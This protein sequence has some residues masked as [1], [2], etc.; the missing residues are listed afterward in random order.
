[1]SKMKQIAALTAMLVGVIMYASPAKSAVCFL[2]D[3][4]G[5]CGGGDI[6]IS[7]GSDSDDNKPEEK[8]EGF[9]VSA[10][11]YEKMKNC[12]DFTS[13]TKSK[14]KEVKYKKGAQ[15]ENTTWSNGICCTNG[16]KYFSKQGRCCPTTGCTCSGGRVW[17]PS[18]EQCECP[19]GKEFVG[20]VCTCAG[21]TVPD[22]KGNCIL[23]DGCTYEYRQATTEDS[24]GLTDLNKNYQCMA[25]INGCQCYTQLIKVSSV[26]ASAGYVVPYNKISNKS[27]T[28]VDEN[29]VTRYQ[30]ICKGTTKSSCSARGKNYEFKPN[31]CVSDTYN[32]GFEVKGDEWGDCVE[33]E[34]KCHYQ[35]TLASRS[36]TC[37]N[38]GNLDDGNSCQKGTCCYDNL[39]KV[40]SIRTENG[41]GNVMPIYNRISNASASCVTLD[42][43]T[44]YETICEG[45]PKS[46]CF[47][48]SNN[49]KFTPNGCV[50]FAYNNDFE[51]KGTE[52]G[53][54]GCDESK[55]AYATIEKCRSGTNSG[56]TASS[57]G[58]YQT[59]ESQG[60]YSTKEA[61]LNSD[62]KV[63][64]TKTANTGDCYKREMKGFL[65]KYD[66][67]K[68][69]AMCGHTSYT[70]EA[71]AFLNTVEYNSERKGEY[72]G[73][74]P[75]TV[76]GKVYYELPEDNSK[77][78]QYPAG[79]YYL[80]YQGRCSS[81]GSGS[82]EQDCPNFDVRALE[83]LRTTDYNSEFTKEVCFTG[84]DGGYVGNFG[85]CEYSHEASNNR[86]SCKKVT[87]EAGKIY[88]V[89]FEISG[90]HDSSCTYQ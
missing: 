45:T 39:S 12:F 5:S 60:Y 86:E 73:I 64:C 43:V 85:T 13:C 18:T 17:N 15:K 26:T 46:A 31:G 48:F 55:G 4:D 41:E 56:C 51:V 61:C 84:R 83:L 50:S 30:T 36:N 35:Y 65:I 10:T 47:R 76:D 44:K 74:P 54:C 33:K 70:A 19:E 24:C 11:E 7:D 9:P 16:E 42:G 32:N 81:S 37:G 27:A 21:N 68:R 58:C 3:D 67:S 34:E 89:K 82:G 53:T 49:M 71:V 78:Y 87:F 38:G 6:E 79:T 25:T 23:P 2:P 22:S 63:T 77:G 20:G 72:A 66:E 90:M 28:C 29:N 52:W 62:Y 69:K 59:C 8:C 1:M 57:G 40:K 80:C 14:T 75:E 88:K